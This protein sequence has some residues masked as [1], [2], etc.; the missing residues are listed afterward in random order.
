MGGRP[1]RIGD[2]L[3]CGEHDQRRAAE[4]GQRLRLPSFTDP[5][6]A[7]VGGFVLVV[8]VV[9]VVVAALIRCAVALGHAFLE[10]WQESS[11]GAAR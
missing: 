5:W 10:E 8:V 6:P 11:G 1:G 3:G 4:R 9:V 2:V 7:N